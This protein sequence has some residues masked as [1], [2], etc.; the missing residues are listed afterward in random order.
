MK[1]DSIKKE[2]IITD[3]SSGVRHMHSFGISH[4]DLSPQNIMIEEN[5]NAIIIDMDSASGFG[6]EQ[7][8]PGLSPWCRWCKTTEAE[9]DI[10]LIA[11]IALFLLLGKKS[12]KLF[13]GKLGRWDEGTLKVTAVLDPYSILSI[14]YTQNAIRIQD[15]G[16][17]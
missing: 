16:D 17:F 2:N 7:H 10:Y 8:K 5:G 14:D 9:N 1:S 3:I 13:Y 11:R 6:N 15:C 12:L 4:N